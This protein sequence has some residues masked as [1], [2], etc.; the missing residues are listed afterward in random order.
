MPPGRH[1]RHENTKTR[2]HDAV[3]ARRTRRAP[4]ERSLLPEEHRRGA[5]DGRRGAED[6]ARG[7]RLVVDDLPERQ[8]V[9]R[10]G[11]HERRE[12]GERR[13]AE[14]RVVSQAGR[15][16]R[17]ERDPEQDVSPRPP[18][19][20]GEDGRVVRLV[21]IIDLVD[22]VGRDVTVRPPARPSRLIGTDAIRRVRRD[23]RPR[24]ARRATRNRRR[25]FSPPPQTR[26]R[27]RRTRTA[28]S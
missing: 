22:L 20:S 7:D 9:D 2:K 21:R 23:A 8:R 15:E 28:R 6:R 26:A 27:R 4:R 24:A 16:E 5:Q 11:A 19:Q 18:R 14:Q 10:P 12:D 13:D 3:V 25:F 17:R 1:A